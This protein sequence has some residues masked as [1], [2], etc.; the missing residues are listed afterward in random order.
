M[1]LLPG[2][3]VLGPWMVKNVA[4]H[5]NPVY[6]VA[7]GVFGGPE[8]SEENDRL[9]KSK[10]KE[11]GL[12]HSLPWLMR[13]PWD[14]SVHSNSGVFE[15]HNPGP[16]VLGLLPLALVAGFWR[17][18]RRPRGGAVVAMLL[19]LLVAG[20]V[21]WFATYQSARFLMPQIA[22]IIALGV[23]GL[24]LASERAG[25]AMPAVARGGLVAMALVGGAW[26]IYYLSS[27]IPVY[28]SALGIY[29]PD[30][31]T[32][33]RF[34]AATGVD[35]LNE[36]AEGERVVYIGEHRIAGA[37]RYEPIASDWFD[38]PRILTEIRRSANND[39][40]IADW[41]TRGVRHVLLNLQELSGYEA[42]YFRPRFAPEELTR[43]DALRA[44]LVEHIVFNSGTG[45][46]VARLPEPAE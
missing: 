35:W 46:F 20:W 36:N 18:W 25:R 32:A 37:R 23:P 12:G 5:G 41:R 6:P 26:P 2:A 19:A 4:Y 30:L 22:A 16:V 29:A 28:Q 31:Y 9:Y 21:V 44:M 11:K 34:N 8:W 3:L 17:A 38:T 40:M 15:G 43:F 33:Q 10:V 42:R 45:V 39:A 1:A 24:L 7:Y 27:I 13:S 14:V